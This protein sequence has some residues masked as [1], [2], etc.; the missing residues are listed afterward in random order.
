MPRRR[1]SAAPLSLFSFQDIVMSVSGIITLVA[2]LIGLRVATSRG[3]PG[4]GAAEPQRADRRTDI[5]TLEGQ[6]TE[7]RLQLAQLAQP[8][9]DPGAGT[10][11]LEALRAAREAAVAAARDLQG[12]AKALL[13]V[14]AEEAALTATVRD[15]E[16]R[17]QALQTRLKQRVPDWIQLR[18]DRPTA[19]AIYL[20]ECSGRQIRCGRMGAPDAA[21]GFE[22][23]AAGRERFAAYLERQ[24]GQDIA[25]VFMVKP[26]AIDYA[27]ELAE[28]VRRQ[29]DFAV[30]Y[31]AL[32][33]AQEIFPRR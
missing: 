26:S 16:G 22:A 23:S 12:C 6:S 18:A 8:V 31:D 13:A 30:G 33:E 9:A 27:I 25:L 17:E 29:H 1:A 24:R 21:A 10:P 15:L 20:V 11:G 5:R 19:A 28:Q 32:L 4:S 3:S 2:L 14:Q 7:L